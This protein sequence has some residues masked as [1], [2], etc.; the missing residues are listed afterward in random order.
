[1]SKMKAV[2]TGGPGAVEVVELERPVAGPTDAV[3]RI[4]ACGICGTDVG[5]VVAGGAPFTG[6]ELLP[7][8]L[9]HEPAGVVVEVGSRVEGLAVGDHVVVNPMDVPS[10]LMGN[11]GP[12]G[13]MREYV[14]IEEAVVGKSLAKVSPE[15]PFAVAAL[16]EPM[17]VAKHAVNRSEARPHHRV[18]VF[19]AGPIGLGAT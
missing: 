16:N 5:Y 11:G 7:V 12:L 15:V 10:G 9:G 6:A 4:R 13:G 18:V 17:A 14:L 19:G 2:R 8:A 3:V 1:M